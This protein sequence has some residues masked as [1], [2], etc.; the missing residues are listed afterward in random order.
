MNSVSIKAEIQST[1]GEIGQCLHIIK[2]EDEDM[3]LVP[4]DD[5]EIKEFR[6]F[7]LR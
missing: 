6:N 1:I 5:E 4:I 3:P 2:K 7:E